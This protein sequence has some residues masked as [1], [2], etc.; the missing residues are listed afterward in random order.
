MDME[1]EELEFDDDL[2]EKAAVVIEELDLNDASS[3]S[4]AQPEDETGDALVTEETAKEISREE[5]E[6]QDFASV[7]EAADETPEETS[8]E[9]EIVVEEEA[10]TEATPETVPSDEDGSP[11][12]TAKEDS[13]EPEDTKEEAALEPESAENTE[14]SLEE[15][16][17]DGIRPMTGEVTRVP[18][19]DGETDDG[20]ATVRPMTDQPVYEPAESS[21]P[22]PDGGIVKP[23]LI[24][25]FFAVLLAAAYV[26]GINYYGTHFLPNTLIDG[27]D[28]GEL[29]AAE[30]REKLATAYDDHIFRFTGRD[31][32]VEELD[33]SE[34]DP[35]RDYEGV[36]GVLS[37][38]ERRTWIVSRKPVKEAPLPFTGTYDAEGLK[39]ALD[40]SALLDPDKTDPPE[41]AYMTFDEES[42]HYVI[43]PEDPGNTVDRDT[44]TA[45]MEEVL[46]K[47]GSSLDLEEIGSYI[48][49]EILSDN[50]EL[51]EKA[52]TFNTL[53]DLQAGVDMGADVVE[54]MSG[55]QLLQLITEEGAPEAYVTGLKNRY[56]TYNT[57]EKRLFKTQDGVTY[58][59]IS[60]AWGWR[61]DEEKTLEALK[62]MLSEAAKVL[63]PGYVPEPLPEPETAQADAA[64]GEGEPAEPVNPFKIE[65]VWK[66]R[67]VVHDRRLDYGSTYAEVDLT[68]QTVYVIQD[69]QTVFTSPCVSGRMTK[70]RM[71]PEGFYDI[72]LK[73]TNK[74]LVGYKPDGSVDYRSPVSYWMPFNG[75]IGFHDATWRGSFGGTIYVYS[76]SHGC[77]NMP[78]SKAKEM[79]SLVYKGMPVIVYY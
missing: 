50:E 53:Q 28:V 10:V 3:E 24:G 61:L 13:S 39:R 46:K 23:V 69:G 8:S 9:A 68:N 70:G 30:A 15:S 51:N 58:K 40:K 71:T 14:V 16:S 41:N 20:Q 2:E 6:P 37:S 67:A 65:A 26:Y 73:Q 36:E 12:E 7:K 11:E 19:S 62:A 49:P 17:D 56:D 63:D 66:N 48:P 5:T 25:L 78:L 18:E 34:A 76:G 52:A 72:K 77:I 43:V 60:A 55:E 75:G 1:F 31:G 35:Q 74:V 4:P 47:G 57:E 38:Q 33:I 45:A 42:G 44:V 29:T 27:V 64:E 54:S 32:A 22:E 59:L 21:A 79:Y